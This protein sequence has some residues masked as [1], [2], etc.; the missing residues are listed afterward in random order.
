MV[1]SPS[2]PSHIHAFSN[3]V[4]SVK[5]IKSIY[6]K[7]EVGLRVP[8][9]CCPIISQGKPLVHPLEPPVR[10][11]WAR[12]GTSSLPKAPVIHQALCLLSPG[13]G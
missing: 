13:E 10:T 3:E 1:F 4:I 2:L 11:L 9:L 12:V 8:L 6:A 7:T 5:W